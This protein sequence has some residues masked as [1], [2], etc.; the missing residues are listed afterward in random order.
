MNLSGI[1]RPDPAMSVIRRPDSTARAIPG[2]LIQFLERASVALGCTADA[3]RVPRVH[4]VSG[5]Q[6]DPDH[7]SIW[8]FVPREFTPGLEATMEGN[9]Q[10]ALTVEHIGPHECYQFKGRCVELRPSTESDRAVVSRCRE[11]FSIAVRHHVPQIASHD[12]ALRRYILEPAVAVRVAVREIFL[13]T[14]GP[15]AGSLLARLEPT[16]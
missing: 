2:V 15:G 4:W 9:G 5:W 6:V 16:S 3:S 8:C 1:L 11:R 10:F 12:A 7:R 14:P 13:Q